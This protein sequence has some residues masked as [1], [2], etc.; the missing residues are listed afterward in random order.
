MRKKKFYVREEPHGQVF[1]G[2]FESRRV[3]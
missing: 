1:R 3:R 2:S